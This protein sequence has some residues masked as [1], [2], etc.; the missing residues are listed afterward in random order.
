MLQATNPKNWIRATS[1]TGGDFFIRID[2]IV[3]MSLS[4]DRRRV[5]LSGGAS[6]TLPPDSESNGVIRAILGDQAK[7][8]VP[9][10]AS[11]SSLPIAPPVAATAKE[12]P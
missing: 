9:V 1:P 3:A 11:K 7:T 2:Q 8:D 6:F 5:F 10:A 4:Q 12:L